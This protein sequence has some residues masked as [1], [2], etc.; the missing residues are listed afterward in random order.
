LNQCKGVSDLLRAFVRLL[1]HLKLDWEIGLHRLPFFTQKAAVLLVGVLVTTLALIGG[2]ATIGG[3][4][5]PG[6]EPAPTVEQPPRPGPPTTTTRPGGRGGTAASGQGA[7]AAAATGATGAPAGGARASTAGRAAGGGTVGAG[8]GRG[9]GTGGT[10]AAT[11][12]V[13]PTTTTACELP[14]PPP[15]DLPCDPLKR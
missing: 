14:L 12:T 3:G 7:A 2:L 1:R 10:A 13:R 9:G 4:L 8:G 15:L 11:T 6:P 5:R